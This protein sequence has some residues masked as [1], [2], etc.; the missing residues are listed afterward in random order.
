[1]VMGS[2]ASRLLPQN[3]GLGYL[4]LSGNLLKPCL[5]L[6]SLQEASYASIA[7]ESSD[8]RKLFHPAHMF[9]CLQDGK[10]AMEGAFINPLLYIIASCKHTDL[11]CEL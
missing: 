11:I 9:I 3:G 5:E 10:Y 6:T 8:A 1:M 4:C 2:S 7:F